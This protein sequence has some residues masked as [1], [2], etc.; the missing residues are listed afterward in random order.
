MKNPV[1]SLFN[2]A[3]RKFKRALRLQ[4]EGD[5]V[6]AF[7]LFAELASEGN[8]EAAYL[9]GQGYLTGKGTAPSLEEGARWTY[10]AAE[11]GHLEAS[12]TLATLYAMG[13]PQGFDPTASVSQ[14]ELHSTFSE[15]KIA[16]QE[17]DFEQAL[18]WAQK[19]AEAGHGEAQALLGHIYIHGPKALQD[20]EQARKWYTASA[21]K[22][23][24]QGCLGLG[25]IL[26]QDTEEDSQRV[27]AVQLLQKAAEGG[28][29][30]ACAAMGWVCEYGISGG[31]IDYPRA[32][33]FY[34][35]AAEGG[36]PSAQARYG[37]ML[38]KG[39]GLEANYIQAESWLRRAAYGGDSEAAAL[40][41]DLYIRGE[42]FLHKPAEAIR[43][44]QFAAE[45]DHLPAARVL[46]VLYLL[47]T[48]GPKDPQKAAYWF[49]MAAMRGDR[50]ADADLGNLILSGVVRPDDEQISLQKRLHQQAEAGDLLGAFNLGV[51]LAQ[52]IG[53][54]PDITEAVRWFELARDGVVN[55]QYWY[56]RM[57]FEGRGVPAD[58]VTGMRWMAKAAE[59]GMPEAC[60][61]VAQLLVTGQV[62]GRQDHPR[63]LALYHQAADGGSVDAL[64]SLGAMYGGG[65]DVPEDR[66]R[67]RAYFEKAAQ[68]GHVLGQLMLGRYLLEGI[69]GD[70]QPEEGRLWLQRAAEQGDE[71]AHALLNDTVY[72]A[73]VTASS[74]NAA[75]GEALAMGG[76]GHLSE[77]QKD[78]EM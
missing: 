9:V 54:T 65:H 10:R 74:V 45:H 41:G 67:A 27:Q 7:S 8:A 40:L 73:Q 23:S 49:N 22:G 24:L 37:V 4:E 18:Y 13:L 12:F 58:P 60:A 38:L 69:G 1:F 66:V 21:Q 57:V 39:V 78:G 70:A 43:W 63:A 75:P 35:Q 71:K 2:S 77:P 53:S 46:A 28:V 59:S 30:L 55:A 6:K 68:Q 16:Q 72:L 19:G 34:R 36:I 64:F 62:D 32:A 52:G 3:E 26:L 33:D 42:Q 15:D 56:G 11:A 5:V 51:C 47:G 20:I 29:S 14:S 48:G 17:P 25:L 44:Y 76:E 50:Q 31:E 61:S